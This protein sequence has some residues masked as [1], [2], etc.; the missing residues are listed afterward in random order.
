VKSAFHGAV[1]GLIGNPR[2]DATRLEDI[3]VDILPR[4]F[5]ANQ[6]DFLLNDALQ[7]GGIPFIY[8]ASGTMTHWEADVHAANADA[9]NCPNAS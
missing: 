8:F 6:T 5:K 3:R 4:N 7:G 1:S 9:R 2:Q